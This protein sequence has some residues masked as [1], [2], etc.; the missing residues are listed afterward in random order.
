MRKVTSRKSTARLDGFEP[1]TPRS[2]VRDT[3]SQ[4]PI[5]PHQ[6]YNLHIHDVFGGESID[7]WLCQN[8]CELLWNELLSPK[9]ERLQAS[10]FVYSTMDTW[11]KNVWLWFMGKLPNSNFIN[12]LSWC[13]AQEYFYRHI[14]FI[15]AFFYFTFTF[16]KC[17]HSK[18]ISR[19]ESALYGTCKFFE[20]TK[21]LLETSHSFV[22]WVSKHIYPWNFLMSSKLS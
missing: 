7:Y 17:V 2:R 6:I 12:L 8:I 4:P 15:K 16:V 5:T 19:G 9:P 10:I 18:L 14:I 21:G 22:S 20:L 1:R 11:M 13:V 3:T